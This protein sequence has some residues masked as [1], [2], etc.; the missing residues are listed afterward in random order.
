MVADG[1]TIDVIYTTS[2]LQVKLDSGATIPSGTT[3]PAGSYT[4]QVYDSNSRTRSSL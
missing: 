4:I 1:A 3:I 2:S